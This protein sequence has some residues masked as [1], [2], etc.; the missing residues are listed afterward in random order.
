M[1]GDETRVRARDPLLC[2]ARDRSLNHQPAHALR[3][4]AAQAASVLHQIT[5]VSRE[6]ELWLGGLFVQV[7]EW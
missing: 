3:L 6:G 2:I 7:G 4:L 1:R 5:F